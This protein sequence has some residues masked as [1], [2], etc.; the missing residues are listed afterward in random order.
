MFVAPT[1]RGAAHGV[2]LGLLEV[3]LA[4]AGARGLH[5]I[6][7]G[8]TERFTAAHRFYEKHLFTRVEPHVLPA[9]FPRMNVDTRFYRRTLPLS[10]ADAVIVRLAERDD[11]PGIVRLLADDPLGSQRERFEDPLPC[12]YVDAFERMRAQGSSELL[13][14]AADGAIVG[15][16]QLTVIYGLS[17]VGMSRAQIE[18]VRVRSDMRGRK[19]GELLVRDAIARSRGH[20]CGLVQLT[21]DK[22]RRDAHRF[23]E[24]LGFVASH[25]GMKLPLS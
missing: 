21:T 9:D 23:Y 11:L 24:R 13:V 5:T 15:C 25:V 18:A 16:L 17:R 1:H 19:I 14:A 12:A 7:L 22:S 3:L 8:T 20:G 4:H 2:A 10:G 6:W